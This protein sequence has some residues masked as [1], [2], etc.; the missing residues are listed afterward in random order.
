MSKLEP[1]RHGGG[2]SCVRQG[3]DGSLQHATGFVH[4]FP[5]AGEVGEPVGD[6]V[7]PIFKSER[8]VLVEGLEEL[9]DEDL[10]KAV[11]SLPFEDL[12]AVERLVKS[13]YDFDVESEEG[14]RRLLELLPVMDPE[15]LKDVMQ[16]LW[17]GYVVQDPDPDLMRAEIKGYL[18]DY[19]KTNG[20]AA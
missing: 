16:E 12:V 19:L 10:A 9:F 4:P 14:I 11:L 7:Q 6:P 13:L 3:G 20:Q 17:P 8:I 15:I 18:M 2:S 1:C 5:T